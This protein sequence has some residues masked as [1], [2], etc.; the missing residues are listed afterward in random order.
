MV[1]KMKVSDYETL[2][3]AVDAVSRMVYCCNEL[4]RSFGQ[5]EAIL[6]VGDLKEIGN[7]RS[8]SSP[9]PRLKLNPPS[10]AIV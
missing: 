9:P 6:R 7:K 1:F 2:K 5:L 8:S 10:F 3:M 4:V